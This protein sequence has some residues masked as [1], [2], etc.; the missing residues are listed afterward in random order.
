MSIS[1]KRRYV[2]NARISKSD[3]KD[4]ANRVQSQ[5]LLSNYAEVQPVLAV[6]SMSEAHAERRSEYLCEETLC[7]NCTAKLVIFSIHTKKLAI[8]FAKELKTTRIGGAFGAVS[9]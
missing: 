9:R 7:L 5:S 3:C 4:S 2:S 1:A 8:L 6:Q